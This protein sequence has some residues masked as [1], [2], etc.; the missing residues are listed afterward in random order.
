MRPY[1]QSAGAA[2]L[3]NQPAIETAGYHVTAGESVFQGAGIAHFRRN[4]RNQRC[5]GS[6]CGRT[7][8]PAGKCS[9]CNSGVKDGTLHEWTLGGKDV[10][11]GLAAS[12]PLVLHERAVGVASAFYGWGAREE[13]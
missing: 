11:R 3:A 1:L 5:A 13:M 7:N 10:S 9:E 2:R 8:V 6:E 4:A 12:A